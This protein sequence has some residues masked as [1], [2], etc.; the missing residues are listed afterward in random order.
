LKRLISPQHCRTP[1]E[2]LAILQ[3]SRPFL[4]ALSGIPV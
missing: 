3:A 1:N 2:L 4:D